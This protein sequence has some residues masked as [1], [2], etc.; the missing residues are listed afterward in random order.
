MKQTLTLEELQAYFI[1][2][3]AG[4][5]DE[6]ETARLENW[7]AAA[8]E[9]EEEWRQLLALWQG[10]TPPRVPNGN[11]LETQ[12]ANLLAR[13]DEAEAPT[14]AFA[15]SWSTRARRWL[16][17][18]APQPRWA[19]AA[20]AVPLLL[21][22][23]RWVDFTRD[24]AWQTVRA[25]FGER[26]QLV[27]E[28]GSRVELNAGSSFSHPKKFSNKTRR[29]KLNGEAFFEVQSGAAPFEVSTPQARVRVLGTAFNVRTW[30]RATT[31]FVQSGKVA[32]RSNNET[33]PKEVLLVAGQAARCA[34]TLLVLSQLE[35]DDALAWRE[36]KLVFRGL[37]LAQVLEGLQRHFNVRIQAE[38]ALL[39]HTVTAS[40]ANEPVA[41]VLEAIAAALNARAV[42]EREG[43]WLRAQKT[44]GRE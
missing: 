42:H 44:G 20:L 3:Q 8:P 4:R 12:W 24:A 9:H 7:R 38:A 18:I 17:Q 14:R 27:L 16:A 2:R 40:F 25:P 37:P 13:V 26:V 5:L 28:D 43:Y 10:A 33:A 11:A 34:D 23:L 1:K 39:G 32:L 41:A 35:K 36:G 6:R 22:A 15:E 19:Y 31:V 29:V 30:E 21:A